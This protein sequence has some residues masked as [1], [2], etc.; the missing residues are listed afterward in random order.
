MA[1]SSKVESY[2]KVNAW[3]DWQQQDPILQSV[4]KKLNMHSMS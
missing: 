1:Q 4:N 3:R 2:L